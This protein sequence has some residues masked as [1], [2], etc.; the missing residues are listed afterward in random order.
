MNLQSMSIIFVIIFLPIILV[1]TYYIQREVDTIT[2]QTS[3]DTKLIDATTDAVSAFEINTS[4]EDLSSVSD[5]LRSI[6]EA[7][8]NVFTTTLATNMGLSGASKSRI[9]PYI[10]AIVY[11]LYD[12]YYIYSPTQQAKVVT[13]P[14]GVYVRVGDPGVKLSAGSYVY[15]YK[16]VEE[17]IDD[18]TELEKLKDSSLNSEEDYGKILYYSTD[19]KGNV[20][21]QIK[22]TTDPDGAYK[23]TSYILKSFIPYSMQY[24]WDNDNNDVIINYTLDN[25]ITVYGTIEG[26][27]YS[28][29]GYLIDYSKL[30][31]IKIDFAE[32]EKSDESYVLTV[33]NSY[34]N[35]AFC[36]KYSQ[37]EIDDLVKNNNITITFNNNITINSEE[38]SSIS[39]HYSGDEISDNKSA[40][41]YYLKAYIFSKWVDENLSD[42]N[43]SEAISDNLK[44]LQDGFSI[45]QSGLILKDSNDSNENKLFWDYTEASIF[46]TGTNNE[47]WNVEN[48]ESNFYEHK[49]KVIKNSIQYNLNLAMATY[50]QGQGDEYYQMPLLSEPE[51]DKLLSNVSVL[52]FMQ[53]LPCG[54][55]TYNNYA[56]V[57]SR[58]NEIMA[59]VDDIYYV[60]VENNANML[61]TNFSIDDYLAL[62]DGKIGV[63]N[64][65]QR[66]FLISKIG[67]NSIDSITLPTAHKIDCNNLDKNDTV[68]LYY[69]SFPSREVKYDK[70]YNSDSRGYEYD[71]VCNLCY[72]CIVNSNYTA[73]GELENNN[74]L[75]KAELIAIAKIRNNTYKSCAVKTNNGM[76]VENFSL[77]KKVS[78]N[79]KFKLNKATECYEIQITLKSTNDKGKYGTNKIWLG[80][81]GK[82]YSCEIGQSTQTIV[83]NNS[84]DWDEHPGLS[85]EG[86][87]EVE[88]V[89]ITYKYK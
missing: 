28:K 78:T 10:P 62:N 34:D 20:T 16:D 13:D 18:Q 73:N 81:E 42:I 85:V 64:S 3:Y 14:Y 65:K 76:Y 50:N 36:K 71:H 25:Y 84:Q 51:W 63:L 86:G 66:D 59:N 89:S 43:P 41:A 55:K 77:P 12:G 4:N 22:C 57:T 80:L 31:N 68:V 29:S 6:I 60:P 32:Q 19:S 46:R 88:I 56:L 7:S 23:T 49:T 58:N 53:G 45:K 1:S 48:S 33:A 82:S 74:N 75:K 37:N 87:A 24:K 2:L 61:D 15:C 17:K 30:T 69:Q 39:K 5:S 47:V 44:N 70:E 72:E 26:V 67:E 9:L 79:P 11:V 8:N 38:N 54:L 83:F 21:D 52:A 35:D 27:Y 40:I